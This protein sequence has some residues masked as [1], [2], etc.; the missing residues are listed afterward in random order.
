MT[1]DALLG[2]NG[3]KGWEIIRS[4]SGKLTLNWQSIRTSPWIIGC[5]GCSYQAQGKAFDADE[6]GVTTILL[7]RPLLADNAG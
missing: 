5:L 7:L 6:I 2:E 4:L 3:A 1:R